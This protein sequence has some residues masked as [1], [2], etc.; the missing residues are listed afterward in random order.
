MR[1]IAAELASDSSKL[2]GG[3]GRQPA[4]PAELIHGW[5]WLLG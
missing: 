5:H 4:I 3:S 1:R 2:R